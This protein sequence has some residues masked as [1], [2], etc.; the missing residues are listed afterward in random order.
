MG[1]INY[2]V[3]PKYKL[4]VEINRYCTD[5]WL[6][7]IEEDMKLIN[8][9][10]EEAQKYT[11]EN[12]KFKD[13]TMDEFSLKYTLA[14]KLIGLLGLADYYLYEYMFMLLLK[15]RNIDFEVL[16]E[17]ELEDHPKYKKYKTIEM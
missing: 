8:S 2:I 17:Y 12:T 13:I 11:E 14:N 16:S 5:M 4:K 3:I 6:S 9:L 10:H 15:Q 7:H 1:W